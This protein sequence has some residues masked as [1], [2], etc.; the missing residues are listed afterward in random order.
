MPG[1][2]SNGALLPVPW[3]DSWSS[4]GEGGAEAAECELGQPDEGGGVVESEGHPCDDPYLGVHRFDQAIAE[5]MV[6]GRVDARKMPA[7]LFPQLGEFGDA[8]AGRP[9]QPAGESVLAFFAFE[10]EYHPQPFPEQVG[11]PEAG[12]GFLDPGELGCLAAGEV[13]GV[14]P[15]RVAGAG[16]VPGVTGG[17]ADRKAAVPD[18]RDGP[19]VAGGAPDLAAG[20]VEGVGGP[21]D[22]VERVGAQDRLRRAGGGRPGDPVRAVS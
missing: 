11:A 21:G 9:G 19:G 13:P 10:L 17:D 4:S 16:E 14:F 22:D 8:A 7:D 5:P 2:G 18:R 3:A 15:Q 12:V 20:L 6:E 1:S